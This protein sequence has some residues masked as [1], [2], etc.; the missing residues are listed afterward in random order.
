MS[1]SVTY[2]ADDGHITIWL[3]GKLDKALV[4]KLASE[5]GHVAR[6]H[7]C[8]LVLCDAREATVHMSTLDIFELPK[9]F[10]EILLETGV[11]LYKFKRALVMSSDVDDFTFF[12]AVS[13]ERGQNVTLFRSV[14]A[15][16][17]WLI[18]K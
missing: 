1:S 13:R 12:E 17:L 9:I 16:R 14:D 5:T 10:V 11:Q 8:Y 18:G 2:D 3:Q 4:L 15:A 6:Q 7:D